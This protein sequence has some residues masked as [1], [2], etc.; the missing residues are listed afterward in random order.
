[1]TIDV[2]DVVHYVTQLMETYKRDA[3]FTELGSY[4]SFAKPGD[5][6][7]VTG[8]YNNEG[9]DVHLST[10]AGEQRMSFTW[11]EYKALYTL[12]NHLFGEIKDEGDEE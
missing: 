3:G 2:Y 11:G 1:M 12:F 7:E 8:W 10:Q 6:L 5:F 4:D 9:F